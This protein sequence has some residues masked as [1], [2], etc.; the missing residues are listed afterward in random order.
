MTS[1]PD[2]NYVDQELHELYEIANQLFESELDKNPRVVPYGTTLRI[3]PTEDHQRLLRQ[4]P[5][6]LPFQDNKAIAEYRKEGLPTR[7]D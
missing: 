7:P 1:S 4:L 5:K 2:Q 6:E 3:S